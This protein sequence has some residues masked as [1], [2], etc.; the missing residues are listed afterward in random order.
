MAEPQKQLKLQEPR[1]FLSYAKEDK[2]KVSAIYRRLLT[3]RLNPWLDVK[4]LLPG[5]DWDK[6]I[7]SAI[8]NARFV[9]VFLSNHSINK[10]GYVQKE[11]G[12]ALD[13]AEQMPEGEL[14]II[15]VRLEECTV[16]ERLRQWQWIDVFRPNS[17]KK[18]IS[19]L[20]VHLPQEK[21]I[22][23]HLS[24]KQNKIPSKESLIDLLLAVKFRKRGEF[25][26]GRAKSGQAAI[27]DGALMELRDKVP[28]VF[29]DL[30]REVDY[31]GKLT[32]RVISKNIPS[33]KL[34]RKKQNLL[35]EIR[36]MLSAPNAHVLITEGNGRCAVDKE[37]FHYILEKYPQGKVYI[38]G[39]ETPIVV[40]NGGIVCCVLMP[41]RLHRSELAEMSA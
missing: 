15:P 22:R 23:N 30:K 20:R 34:Y 4:D 7:I 38:V 2:G 18:I 41:L 5:Q 13:V 11:I 8:R 12:E 16:P 40:E 39:T 24:E 21:D 29:K 33:K 27:S 26:Y 35:K 9:L 32:D 37:Y 3:E 6:V 25:Y 31:V 10:R 1:I 36:P 14:F 19:T 28:T 17:F